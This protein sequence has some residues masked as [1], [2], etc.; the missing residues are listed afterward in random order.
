MRAQVSPKAARHL[1]CNLVVVGQE[2]PLKHH[3]FT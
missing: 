1:E 3:H 2:M